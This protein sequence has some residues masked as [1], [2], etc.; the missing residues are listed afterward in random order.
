MINFQKAY[1]KGRKDEIHKIENYDKALADQEIIWHLHH[2]L[3][4]T[5]DDEF[6]HSADE[7][8]RMNMYYHRPYFELIFLTEAEHKALHSSDKGMSPETK[9][10]HKE[11]RKKPR[12]GMKG[13][14]PVNSG[15][16]NS[17]FGKK[18]YDKYKVTHKDNPKL[19]QKEYGYYKYNHKCSWE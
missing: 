3:E 8:K 10:R 1:E 11:S 5:L 4:L 6:A 13:I 14:I 18:F 2:R 19:Y 9:K 7:L 15:V 16:P 17:T 12:P